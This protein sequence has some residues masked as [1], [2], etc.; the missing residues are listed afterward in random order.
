[1]SNN[2][3]AILDPDLQ[4]DQSSSNSSSSNSSSSSSSSSQ[5]SQ[6]SQPS[7]SSL[8]DLSG[9]AHLEMARHRNAGIFNAISATPP[10]TTHIQ[11]SN[12]V[13]K[14]VII[15]TA[16]YVD[17]VRDLVSEIR[18]SD[19]KK[20]I[21]VG[22]A[23]QPFNVRKLDGDG[24]DK[25]KIDIGTVAD[26]SV[27][28]AVYGTLLEDVVR[29]IDANASLDCTYVSAADGFTINKQREVVARIVPFLAALDNF[30]NGIEIPIEFEANVE[31]KNETIRVADVKIATGG[32]FALAIQ[33]DKS[34]NIS[35]TN[36]TTLGALNTLNEVKD[37]I[38][39]LNILRERIVIISKFIDAQEIEYK[40]NPN[41]DVL[42][43]YRAL[44][45]VVNKM[46]N[47]NAEVDVKEH[48][49]GMNTELVLNMLSGSGQTANLFKRFTFQKNGDTDKANLIDMMRWLANAM[50]F[51]KP[52]LTYAPKDFGIDAKSRKRG[53]ASVSDVVHAV[54][55][56]DMMR[57]SPA[58]YT[59]LPSNKRHIKLNVDQVR[60]ILLN[61]N[62]ADYADWTVHH[63]HDG[64]FDDIMTLHLLQR[65]C[66]KVHVYCIC[67]VDPQSETKYLS[68]IAT[69]LKGIGM[70]NLGDYRFYIDRELGNQKAYDTTYGLP[71]NAPRVGLKHTNYIGIRFAYDQ[72]QARVTTPKKSYWSVDTD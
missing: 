68:N 1:M 4:T 55:L 53:S 15:S 24:I 34:Q 18:E 25:K 17:T 11:V 38:G 60:T 22:Q 23:A 57:S 40:N 42:D 65:W 19:Q 63:I 6:A 71:D 64:E 51:F 31:I 47:N 43:Y 72:D 45:E 66:R 46:L 21:P 49:Q 37:A 70:E 33:E 20:A 61:F 10:S 56:L 28:A 29:F 41:R 5:A 58:N 9:T 67:P 30:F 3:F 54:C 50:L 69:C 32:T 2:P 36:V 14:E 62:P 39:K 12:M 59:D 27:N 26:F 7:S 48:T 44:N 52:V 16:Q 8:F 35:N 13:G